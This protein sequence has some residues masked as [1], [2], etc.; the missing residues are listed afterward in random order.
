MRA[1]C[2]R[3]A[4]PPV[5]SAGMGGKGEGDRLP[6]VQFWHDRSPPDYIGELL[7]TFE[8]QNPG[9]PHM[10]FDVVAAERLIAEHFTSREVAA[11]RAC[12]VPAMQADYFRYCAALAMGGLYCDADVRCVG[13]LRGF[14]P[15]AGEGWLMQRPH[16]A[17]VNGLFAFGSPGHP[18]LELTV[19]LVTHSIESRRWRSVYRAT[20]P[21]LWTALALARAGGSFEAALAKAPDAGW[22]EYL[23]FCAEAIGP[24]ERL[25]RALERVRLRQMEEFDPLLKTT[26]IHFPYKESEAHWQRAREIYAT[27]SLEAG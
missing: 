24:Y 5:K 7:E 19:E 4:R 14:M 22:E 9:I 12:A 8:A 2:R 21:A 25:R 17:V 16:G 26:L 6:I 15:V 10:V 20:G 1:E 18:F 27:P 11:F 13:D 23:R 3:A